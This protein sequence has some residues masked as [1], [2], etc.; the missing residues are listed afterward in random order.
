MAM[1]T[2]PQ[3]LVV[4]GSDSSGG[5][6]IVRDIETLAAFGLRACVAV[7]AVTVQTHDEM[8]AIQPMPADLVAAQMRAAFEN[9][10]AAA[11]IGMLGTTE[12]VEAVASVLRERASVPVVLDPV[13]AASSGR[14][15]ADGEALAAL[16]HTLLP[17]CSVV[18]P[19]LPELAMLTGT[20]EAVDEQDIVEQAGVLLDAG[21][22]AVL[23]KGGHATGDQSV[24]LLLRPGFPP[25]RFT[26]RRLNAKLRGSGCMLASALAAGL[27]VGAPLEEAAHDARRHVLRQLHRHVSGSGASEHETISQC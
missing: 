22:P 20:Q 26:A 11:K 15:L 4:A 27:A 23:A 8:R 18:T 5:A 14:A 19:N 3:V 16:K 2:D 7:T 24:D 25:L 10:V 9:L 17:L 12:A 6:G 13:L 21:A 1:R